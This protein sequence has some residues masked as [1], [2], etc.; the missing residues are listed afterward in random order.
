MGTEIGCAAGILWQ[1]TDFIPQGF[2][3]RFGRFH[4]RFLAV[5][6]KAVFR[7]SYTM[8]SFL[9]EYKSFSMI[10]RKKTRRPESAPAS[11]AAIDG[12]SVIFLRKIPFRPLKKPGP[13]R[14]R[15]TDI[16]FKSAVLRPRKPERLISSRHH[17]HSCYDRSLF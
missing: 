10:F 11:T 14:G 4:G 6:L 15:R 5:F 3:R 2:F 12:T 7:E 1:K 8:A 17:R 9:T 16:S 13:M